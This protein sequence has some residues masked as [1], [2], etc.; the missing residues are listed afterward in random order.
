MPITLEEKL[1]ALREVDRIYAL[2]KTWHR[3]VPNE[4]RPNFEAAARAVMKRALGEPIESKREPLHI[5]DG[6]MMHAHSPRTARVIERTLK[7]GVIHPDVLHS[8]QSGR[9]KRPARSVQKPRRM[10][11]DPSYLPDPELYIEHSDAD[12]HYPSHFEPGAGFQ[13]RTHVEPTHVELQQPP[14]RAAQQIPTTGAASGRGG[15]V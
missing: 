5:R 3:L 2:A 15:Y 9:V 11:P 12:L 14:A 10:G 13:P 7:N 4:K 8:Y 6:A 1:K